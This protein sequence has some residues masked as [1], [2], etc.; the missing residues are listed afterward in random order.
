[1]QAI[2]WFWGLV[3]LTIAHSLPALAQDR[4]AVVLMYH[5]FGED[6]LPSTNIRLEQFDAHIAE[7]TNGNYTVLPLSEVVAKLKAREPLPEKTVSIT[8]DDAFKS[9]FTEGWPRLKAAGLP[10]TVFVSTDP[11][12]ERR[13]NYMSWDDVRALAADGVEIGHHTASH[14]H[15]I[16][17]GLEYS[18]E[19]VRR[20]SARF[21]A[22]L[23]YVPTLFAYPYGEYDVTHM[24]QMEGEGFEAA[25]GQF[26]GPA[27]FWS[28]PFAMPRFA[29]NERY[30]DMERF[31]L[32]AGTKALPIED[33]VP[34]D[35]VLSPETNPPV[36]G[37][38]VDSTVNGLSAMACYPS[39]LGQAAELLRL[40]NN[41]MEVRFD[42]PFPPG[43]NRINCTMPSNDRRWYW[44]GSFFYVPGGKLD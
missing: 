5:R 26:S 31:R 18:L 4:S 38:T 15:M 22:E 17:E 20:A 34:A 32:I 35:P 21:E 29:I 39:H 23:G 42:K 36:F 1:M 19:D 33:Q 6:G 2:K 37:F 27:A 40:N 11:L 30:G 10:M 44:L 9:V 24:K 3:L 14:L 43:R 13:P 12:D 25:F 41:R 7:L 8:V 28:H 16:Y